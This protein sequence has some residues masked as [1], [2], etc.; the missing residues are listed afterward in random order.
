MLRQVTPNAVT[1][2]VALLRPASVSLRVFTTG[3][4]GTNLISS[5]TAPNAP[6]ATTAIGKNLHVV[7]VTVR[8]QTSLTP[9]TIYCY[10]MTF[11]E[12]GQTRTLADAATKPGEAP[13]DK[14]FAYAPHDFPSFALPPADLNYL[15]LVHGSCRKPHGGPLPK[16]Q[17]PGPDQLSTLDGLIAT[18]ANNAMQRPHQLLLTGDQIY[19]DDCDDVL[20]MALTDAGDTLFGWNA[21]EELPAVAPDLPYKAADLPA[22]TRYDLITRAG[23]TGD[24]RRN[25]VISLSEFFAMYLFVWS[26]VLWYD[27]LT[28]DEFV[29]ALP[30]SAAPGPDIQKGFDDRQAAVGSFRK[31][32]PIVRR[33]LANIPTYMI[34]D[35]HEVTDDFN[36]T[37]HFVD[38]VYAQP[39]ARRLMQNA[40]IAFSICQTWG[41]LPEQFDPGSPSA[42]GTTLLSLLAQVSA[43]P[44][45]SKTYDSLQSQFMQLVGVHE[46]SA[47]NDGTDGTFHAFHD[48]TEADEIVVEGVRINTKAL[49]YNFSVEGPAHQVILTDTRTWR[50]FVAGSK[51]PS[52]LYKQLDDQLNRL[53]P[54]LEGR[55]QLVVFTTNAPPIALIRLAAESVLVPL[56]HHGPD[57]D[58][59]Y[60]S[61]FFPSRIFDEM[62]VAVTKR[63]PMHGDTITGSVLFLSG[64]VH[65]SFSSRLAYWADA[66]LGDATPQKAKVVVGQLVSSSLKNEA[67]ATR[68]VGLGG[69]AHPPHGFWIK[70]A[71]YIGALSGALAGSIAGGLSSG[72]EAA[73]RDGAIGA[74]AGALLVLVLENIL[75]GRSLP[76]HSPEAYVGWNIAVGGTDKIITKPGSYP[77]NVTTAAPTFEQNLNPT[78]LKGVLLTPDYRYRLDY[79]S[80]VRAGQTAATAAGAGTPSSTDKN[81]AAQSFA[82]AAE[83]RRDLI[84]SG[85]RLPDCIGN[86]AIGEITFTW[87]AGDAATTTG[88]LVKHRVHWQSPGADGKAM[89]ADYDVSLDV[90]DKNYPDLTQ[91]IAP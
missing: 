74:V 15:R 50:G 49:R 83:L 33:A 67:E 41:N 82:N 76:P 47:M 12:G 9:G 45:N 72:K 58:D 13:P 87:P 7:A 43:A 63:L 36:M 88:K 11:V 39:L 52:F 40:L 21:A 17:T 29:L 78:E 85:A 64:D 31:T 69:Y 46:R 66:R 54:P 57:L 84:T 68:A 75:L 30:A 1:V 48:G 38:N 28:F 6:R 81:A 77:L 56:I 5:D 23:F 27:P 32:L 55:L 20:L 70:S 65:F 73:L 3:S 8:S 35:D 59:L 26:D 37:K 62:L 34:L 60:D 80:T 79:L 51:Y 61:W 14:P 42:P 53:V 2:W 4:P 16:D 90:D 91:S 10:D 24:D 89:W 18:D 71:P 22:T 25:H 19:A 86:N 44:N